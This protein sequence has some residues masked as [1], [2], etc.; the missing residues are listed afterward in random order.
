VNTKNVLLGALVI[1][2]LIFASLTIVEHGQVATST[3]TT[4]MIG[5]ATATTT[6]LT[7]TTQ[8]A[9]RTV[10]ASTISS[11]DLN[12][13]TSSAVV[14][15]SETACIPSSGYISTTTLSEES[16]TTTVQVVYDGTACDFGDSYFEAP[17]AILIPANTLIWTNFQLQENG[18]Y[19]V[20]GSIHF[21]S[22]PSAL[23][24]NITVAVY[25][26]GNLSGSSTTPVSQLPNEVTNSSLIPSSNSSNPIFALTGVTPTGG[27]GTQTGSALDLTGSTISIAFMSD[28][29]LWI[30]G[31][32][33]EDMSKGSGEQFGQSFGQLYG[34]Y[35]WSGSGSTLPNSLPQPTTMVTFE[36]QISGSYSA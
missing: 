34:T 24:A 29:P 31:W 13:T 6:I 15:S 2:T 28:K 16:T 1:L 26:N 21:L 20:G 30:S 36:L 23:G 25:L 35:E 17:S 27:V 9:T 32:T 10:T 12:S 18:N 19:Y 7:T 11:S 4:T 8:T 14:E 3:A 22:F 5:T 33:P